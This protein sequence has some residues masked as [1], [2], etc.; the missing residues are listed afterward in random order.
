MRS[1]SSRL[2]KKKREYSDSGP[3]SASASASASA[4]LSSNSPPSPRTH[5]GV[6]GGRSEPPPTLSSHSFSSSSKEKE[7]SHNTGGKKADPKKSIFSRPTA[8][9]E[10]KVN[11]SGNAYE[12]GGTPLLPFSLLSSSS[13]F[14]LSFHSISRAAILYLS[15][16]LVGLFIPILFL[17]I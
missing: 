12:F 4:S 15:T 2:V 7:L 10:S 9:S 5:Y 6:G 8:T 13:S 1:V 14:S 17:M 3:S 16:F 11:R